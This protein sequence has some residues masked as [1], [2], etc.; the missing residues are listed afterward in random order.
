M[1]S[2]LLFFNARSWIFTTAIGPVRREEWSTWYIICYGASL[3]AAMLKSSTICPNSYV[4]CAPYRYVSKSRIWKKLSSLT[5][6]QCLSATYTTSVC[7][8]ES[9]DRNFSLS[10]PAKTPCHHRP[11]HQQSNESNMRTKS[12]EGANYAESGI[13][14]RRE[15]R[16]AA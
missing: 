3:L 8:K 14:E 1:A 7:Q 4:I 9:S 12:R 5:L 11:L 16:E 15:W 10:S 13:A 6:P 2:D